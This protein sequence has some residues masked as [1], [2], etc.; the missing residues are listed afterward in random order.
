MVMT[1]LFSKVV[2]GSMAFVYIPY[3]FPLAL[4]GD[5]II[6]ILYNKLCF[7]HFNGLCIFIESEIVFK[8]GFEF[9]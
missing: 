3:F 8:D 5:Y 6:I 7:G 2:L 4:I 9:Q 1:L